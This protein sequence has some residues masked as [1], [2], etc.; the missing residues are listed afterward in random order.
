MTAP[1]E[2]ALAALHH[3]HERLAAALDGR[4]DAATLPSYCTDWTIGQLLTHMGSGS[5]IFVG[6][7]DAGVDGRP[8]PDSSEWQPVWDRWNAL[9]PAEQTE[10]GVE[11]SQSFLDRVDKLSD[12][13]RDAWRLDVFGAER[14]F[15]GIIRMRLAEHA[16]HTWD[17]VVALQPDA[18]LDREAA[19]LI[20]DQ[21]GWIAGFVAKPSETPTRVRLTATDLDRTFRL[22]VGAESVT[23]A[24]DT[25]SD[26]IEADAAVAMPG[27]AL[28]RLVYGRLDPDHTPAAD[29][30]GVELD[31]LRARFP[32]V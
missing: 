20:L 12:E 10:R 24:E 26:A 18:V 23:L 11:A 2:A 1:T 6:M 19:A 4:Q 13:E 7:I 28:V 14:D 31:F 8:A 29:V 22:D 3:S 17:A 30:T 16:V 9:P 25:G 21:L 27:E 5:E 15:E 32:G